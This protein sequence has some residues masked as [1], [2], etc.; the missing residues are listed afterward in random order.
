MVSTTLDALILF[1]LCLTGHFSHVPRRPHDRERAG[2]I[3]SG[4][5]FIYEEHSSGIK[6]WTDGITWSPSRIL[7]NFLVYRELDQTMAPGEKKRALKKPN[8]KR[9]SNGGIT[10]PTSNSG[11]FSNAIA[12]GHR[13]SF[14]EPSEYNP[15]PSP[16]SVSSNPN[17][18]TN[19]GT[20]NKDPVRDLVGSLTDSY[21]FKEGGLVKKTIS[22]KYRGISHHLVSYYTIDDAL[23]QRLNSP[24]RDPTIRGTKVREDLLFSQTF[25]ASIDEL[26][27]T[28]PDGRVV[29]GGYMAIPQSIDGSGLLGHPMHHINNPGYDGFMQQSQVQP[30]L[31]GFS[32]SISPTYEPQPQLAQNF[33]SQ[34][35]VQSTGYGEEPPQQTWYM[36][37]WRDHNQQPM[38]LAQQTQFQPSGFS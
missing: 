31:T 30:P 6:R 26:A 15:N 34:A 19:G 28:T 5:V 18:T 27:L 22:V 10:K 38:A 11:M 12:S 23:S 33:N 37:S 20:P 29:A 13:P 24:S 14:S 1:E 21:D 7:G 32:M 35:A 17:A 25:R 36:S 8:N 2:L 3:R 9:G 16:G 4:M